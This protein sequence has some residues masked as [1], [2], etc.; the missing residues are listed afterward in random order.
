MYKVCVFSIYAQR[1][2][3]IENINDIKLRLKD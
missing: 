3:I 1:I 2:T